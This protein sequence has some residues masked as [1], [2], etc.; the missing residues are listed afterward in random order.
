MQLNCNNEENK[1]DMGIIARKDIMNM[2]HRSIIDLHGNAVT[3]MVGTGN[4][5]AVSG[6]NPNMIDPKSKVSQQYLQIIIKKMF[7]ND[8]ASKFGSSEFGDASNWGDA[9]NG[10]RSASA[11]TDNN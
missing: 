4:P 10:G 1:L 6:A 3:Q 7:N 9:S 8:D 11:I 2:G 5:N